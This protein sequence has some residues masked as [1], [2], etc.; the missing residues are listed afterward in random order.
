MLHPHDAKR[1]LPYELPAWQNLLGLATV[2][3]TI[4]GLTWLLGL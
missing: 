1:R 2:L 3:A 4:V